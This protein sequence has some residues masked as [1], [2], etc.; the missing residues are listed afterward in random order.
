MHRMTWP[1]VICVAVSVL[2]IALS[3]PLLLAD[4]IALAF[5]SIVASGGAWAVYGALADARESQHVRPVNVVDF[6]RTPDLDIPDYETHQI[7][8]TRILCAHAN[9]GQMGTLHEMGWDEAR[10]YVC[11]A[12]TRATNPTEAA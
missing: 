2:G 1:E 4:Q 10:G 5:L 3:V 7:L 8:E 11:K 12:H 9:C 6:R